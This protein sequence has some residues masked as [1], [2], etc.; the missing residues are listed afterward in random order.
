MHTFDYI[1][2]MS[3]GW[4]LPLL[5]IVIIFYVLEEKD[6]QTEYSNAKDILDKRYAS[7]GIAK[8]EYIEKS[9]YLKKYALHV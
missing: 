4:L 9:N 7:G 1:W 3:F 6:H 2:D 8:Q 5:I